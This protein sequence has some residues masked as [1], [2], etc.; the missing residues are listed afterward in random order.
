MSLTLDEDGSSLSEDLAAYP[1]TSGARLVGVSQGVHDAISLP[2]DSG[3]VL[4]VRV[5]V[6][7]QAQVHEVAAGA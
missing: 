5:F 1:L 2:L 3:S 7:N 6:K 4:D